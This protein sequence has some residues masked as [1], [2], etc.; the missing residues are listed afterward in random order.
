FDDE[1][2]ETNRGEVYR[3]IA[4]VAEIIRIYHSHHAY[5]TSYEFSGEFKEENDDGE[6]SKRTMLYYW[7]AKKLL[8]SGWDVGLSGNKVV[9]Y[10]K[11]TGA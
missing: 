10:R 9:V 6:T 3:V 4:T 8:H 11:G 5:S 2:S 7:K 1:Y